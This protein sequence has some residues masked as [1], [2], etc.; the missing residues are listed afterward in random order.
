MHRK[1]NR[2]S[3]VIPVYNSENTI[4][5][6][7]DDIIRV[8]NDYNFEIVLVNDASKDNSHN[9]CVEKH[10]QHPK[11]VRY[12][13]LSRNFGEHNTVIAGL[14]QCVGDFAIIMDDDFQ[15]PPEEIIKV[16]DYMLSHHFDVVYSRYDEKM[17]SWFRNIG[18]WFN[19]R[20][21]TL[22][23]KKPDDLYLSSFK[24]MN[25]FIINEITK[26]RAPYTYIDGLI[27]RVTANI[28]QITVIHNE[29][30]EGK[31]N[32]NIKKLV[33]LWMNMFVNFSI[34]PLRISL[35]IGIILT[36]FGFGMIVYF[37]LQIFIFD[38]YGEW[39]AGWPSL[40]VCVITFS[41]TQLI[42]LG[43]IGEYLGKLFLSYN[44]T[45]QFIIKEH[46]DTVT[47]E[48]RLGGTQS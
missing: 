42:L 12:F 35:L 39:P 22:L 9:I 14:N 20:V 16:Y 6:L 1:K 4:G 3:I 8:L 29:R 37:I 26:Y 23:L 33:S 18:S 40:I 47:D 38:P 17:H 43:L 48:I 44:L 32:Y 13:R 45:P 5:K 10:M 7:V 15:N 41:G 24:C 28:G 2:L 31:S 30:K 19:D 21:T 27:L 11:L 34:I 36:L 25:R 46:Y